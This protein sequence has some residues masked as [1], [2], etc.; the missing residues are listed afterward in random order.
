MEEFLAS[1]EAWGVDPVEYA[2]RGTPPGIRCN[3]C[4][5]RRLAEGMEDGEPEIQRLVSKMH[6]LYRYGV[7]ELPD[8][9]PPRWH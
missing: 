3:T 8:G 6:N 7:A 4:M 5:K 2:F 1:C 9:K